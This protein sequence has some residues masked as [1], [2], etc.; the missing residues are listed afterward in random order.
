MRL[1]YLI[2]LAIDN[3]VLASINLNKEGLTKASKDGKK[4]IH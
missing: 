1:E 4:M 2:N 3:V